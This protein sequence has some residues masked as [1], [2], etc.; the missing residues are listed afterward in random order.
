MSHS[1][2]AQLGQNIVENSA[3]AGTLSERAQ[4]SYSD[5]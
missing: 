5:W 3:G 1:L 4:W 2:G